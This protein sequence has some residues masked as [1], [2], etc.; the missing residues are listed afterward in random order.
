MKNLITLMLVCFALSAIG[1]RKISE[2]TAVVTPV[3]TD[4]LPIVNASATKKI[5]LTQIC[6]FCEYS[7]ST[8]WK[9]GAG[10]SSLMDKRSTTGSGNY[11]FTAGRHAINSG[12]SGIAIG[13]SARNTATRSLVI[14][15]ESYN[16]GYGGT[17]VGDTCYNTGASGVVIG[18]QCG[19]TGIDGIAIGQGAV[20]T[21]NQGIMIGQSGSVSASNGVAIGFG[22]TARV[23]RTTNIS[24]VITNRKSDVTADGDPA[25]YM[26]GAQVVLLSRIDTVTSTGIAYITLPSG[27]RFFPDEVGFIATSANTVSV[28]PTISYGVSGNNAALLVAAVTVGISA[29]GDRD[30]KQTLVTADGQTSLTAEVT[31]AA[32][33][34]TL[35]GR[36]YFK[37]LLI[38]S[39]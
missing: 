11:S 34:T 1:Q 31:V 19:N 21:A 10:T 4:V 14:G 17:V 33:A 2:M 13:D 15:Y 12:I 16:T 23:A 32:T 29:D 3:S 39:Q 20:V 9:V 24:G 30:R 8:F 27:I 35:I 26:S 37:G 28:Q 6:N 38:E 5:T 7:D 25:L 22:A 36:Y 18:L